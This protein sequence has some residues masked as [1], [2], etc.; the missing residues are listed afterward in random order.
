[1]INV[2]YPIATAVIFDDIVF[3]IHL[4]SRHQ[5]KQ[6]IDIAIA[7][8]SRWCNEERMVVRAKLLVSFWGLYLTYDQSME[9]SV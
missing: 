8:F 4:E 3:P 1:V 2:Q 5:I 9:G 6:E 7:W